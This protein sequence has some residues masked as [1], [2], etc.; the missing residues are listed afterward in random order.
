[1]VAPM[2]CRRRCRR[3]MLRVVSSRCG[4][5]RWQLSTLFQPPLELSLTL[6]LSL[7]FGVLMRVFNR[8]CR[9]S[10]ELGDLISSFE[11]TFH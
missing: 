7:C 8:R 3:V 6:T 2:V 1:M 10:I 5:M 11:R 9:R 4:G